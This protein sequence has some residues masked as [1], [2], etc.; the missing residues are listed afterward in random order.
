MYNPRLKG[1]MI[2][3]FLESD[4]T[5]TVI[6]ESELRGSVL[7]GNSLKL[8][9]GY[10]ILEVLTDFHMVENGTATTFGTRKVYADGCQAVELPDSKNF[11][12]GYLYIHVIRE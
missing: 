8:P 9:K 10:S 5:N 11:D 6:V 12:Y 2:R 7:S 1:K 3:F 4:S